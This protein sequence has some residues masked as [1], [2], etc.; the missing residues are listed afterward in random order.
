MNIVNLIGRLTKDP[1]VSVGGSGKTYCKFSLAVNRLGKD[2]GADFINCV[3]FG[4]T[5]DL[6]EKYLKKGS[7][8]AVNGRIQTGK[9]EKSGVTHYTTEIMVGTVEF[10]GDS[11]KGIS[12]KDVA[13]YF[14]GEIIG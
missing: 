8:L 1:E 4:K 11:G 10:L 2:A 3:A 14:G 12:D 7:R 13:D 9:Y 5:A 6:I